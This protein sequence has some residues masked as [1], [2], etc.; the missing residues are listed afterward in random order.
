[1]NLIDCVSVSFFNKLEIKSSL[2]REQV[3]VS[4]VSILRSRLLAV[5]GLHWHACD[6]TTFSYSN[7]IHHF[8]V[9]F[10]YICVYVYVCQTDVNL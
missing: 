9:L 5:F 6:E 3:L 8:L 1:M 10:P 7:K 4:V 2:R